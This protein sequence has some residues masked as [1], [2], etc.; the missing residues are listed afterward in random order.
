MKEDASKIFLLSRGQKLKLDISQMSLIT[1]N[2]LVQTAET[3][4]H[5]LQVNGEL[6]RHLNQL[7]TGL[8]DV[9]KKAI[10]GIHQRFDAL[11]PDGKQANEDSDST[12]SEELIIDEEER[13]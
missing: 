6:S 3:Y 8:I 1:N 11:I 10:D 4:L 7:K 12:D 5:I 2:G 13:A 9:H